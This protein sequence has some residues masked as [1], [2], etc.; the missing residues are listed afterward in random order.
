VNHKLLF[1][2]YRRRHQFV[3]EALDSLGREAPVE[4]MLNLGAGEGDLDAL[5]AGYA[6]ALDA[7]DANEGDVAYAKE[8]NADLTNVRYRVEDGQCLSYGDATFDVVV[9]TEVIEHVADPH[10]LLRETRRVL[11]PSGHLVL[12]CPSRAFPVTY[13]P[14]NRALHA[15]G[16]DDSAPTLPIGAYGFGHSWLVDDG[17]LERWLARYDFEVV[18]KRRLSRHL[19]GLVECYGPGLVQRVLKSNAGNREG[20]RRAVALTPSRGDPPLVA[21]TDAIVA[22]D[23]SL[24]AFGDRSV[25]LGYL[26]RRAT[27]EA[28]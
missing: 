7:C 14:I 9:C 15:L 5:L 26:V 12:T 13:D 28:R 18:R 23:E 22:L 6:Q 8:L 2:T 27:A 17:E 16:R 20:G 4:R 3:R 24:F 1:P 19:A 25:G 10:A 21:I 11:R